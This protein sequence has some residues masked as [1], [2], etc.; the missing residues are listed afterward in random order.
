MNCV[1]MINSYTCR[2]VTSQS[3]CVKSRCKLLTGLN[4]AFGLW[5]HDL[6]FDFDRAIPRLRKSLQMA[7]E[8]CYINIIRRQTSFVCTLLDKG[9]LV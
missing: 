5:V 3:R 2:A 8:V 1:G 7:T 6:C 9:E 4:T